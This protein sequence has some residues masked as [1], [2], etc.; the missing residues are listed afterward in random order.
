M[1]AGLVEVYSKAGIDLEAQVDC[2][3][4]KGSDSESAQTG[5]CKSHIGQQL[6]CTALHSG[7]WC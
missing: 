7:K 5:E 1:D 3:D 6:P 2:K 4:Y